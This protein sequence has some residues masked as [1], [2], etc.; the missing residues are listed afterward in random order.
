MDRFTRHLKTPFTGLTEM[1]ESI[2]FPG[3]DAASIIEARRRDIEAVLE[4]NRIIYAGAQALV[5]KQIEVLRITMSAALATMT[6]A[7]NVGNPV[8]MANRQ[9]EIVNAAFHESLRQMRELAEIVRTAQADAFE[10]VKTKVPRDADA[11]VPEGKARARV[12]S[13]PKVAAVREST[14]KA[15]TARGAQA[16]RPAKPVALKVARKSPAAPA[17]APAKAATEATAEK[18]SVKPVVEAAKTARG[19]KVAEPKG[20][21]SSAKAGKAASAKASTAPRKGRG[22]SAAK[23]DTQAKAKV[24]SK[25]PA[26]AASKA[27]AKAA[28]KAPAKAASKEPAKS[29]SPAARKQASAA[30]AAAAVAPAP[31]VA[32][33]AAATTAVAA[34]IAV[35]AP[36]PAGIVAPVPMPVATPAPVA[37]A[38]AGSVAASGSA[39]TAKQE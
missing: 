18:S 10:V 4:A 24:V 14:L 33:A 16:A 13:T 34:P 32:A 19:R 3:F 35:P 7:R 20:S 9:R 17:S 39:R 11:S 8:D 5:Q 30:P 29:A 38:Q 31:A 1:F 28:S 22:Q 23:V 26:K 36:T 6:E 27:P 12:V 15:K 25:A 37:P 2:K 21:G